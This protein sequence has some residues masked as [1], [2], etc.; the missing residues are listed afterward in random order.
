MAVLQEAQQSDTNKSSMT[1]ATLPASPNHVISVTGQEKEQQI[2]KQQADSWER[3]EESDGGTTPTSDGP[4]HSVPQLQRWNS[5]RINAFRTLATFWDFMILG[6]NDAVYG[7]S[8]RAR[9]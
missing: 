8:S 7:T 4:V 6:A 3:D 1:S 9:W 2:R 5:P